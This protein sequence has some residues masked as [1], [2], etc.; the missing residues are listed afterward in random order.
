MLMPILGERENFVN[1]SPFIG[2]WFKYFMITLDTYFFWFIH[3][4]FIR[5]IINVNAYLSY[6]TSQWGSLI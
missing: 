6:F 4:D 5:D 3:L 1:G 2:F